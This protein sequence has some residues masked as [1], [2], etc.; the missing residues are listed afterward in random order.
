M[1]L[2]VYSYSYTH[3]ECTRN[4]ISVGFLKHEID[5]CMN[6]NCL[7]RR[8]RVDGT[9]YNC[10]D[11][12][13]ALCNPPE[14]DKFVSLSEV[15][16]YIVLALQKFKLV[17]DDKISEYDTKFTDLTYEI[18]CLKSANTNLQNL[19]TGALQTINTLSTRCNQLSDALVDLK[20][21]NNLI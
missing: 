2:G 1:N 13:C 8:K 4:S 18:N 20:L 16:P 17:Y 15:T 14:D 6:S 5:E 9:T 3:S 11:N 19:L 21:K 7:G 10:G 12:T